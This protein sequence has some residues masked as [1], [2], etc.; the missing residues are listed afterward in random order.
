MKQIMVFGTF[1]GLHPGHLD[2]F[3]QAKDYGDYLTVVIARDINV[4]KIK[5]KLPKYSETERLKQIIALKQV[6]RPILGQ[7]KDVYKVIRDEKPDII[8]LGYDQ[9]K[10]TNNLVKKFPKIKIIR[11]KPYKPEIY[12][13]SKLNK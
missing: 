2:F 8:A 1:D 5:G 13:S 9:E 10:Y 7:I 4:K 6:D 11:L 3:K 12:K